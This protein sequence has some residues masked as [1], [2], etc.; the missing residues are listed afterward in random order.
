ME[1]KSIMQ[2]KL[3]MKIKNKTKSCSHSHRKT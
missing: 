1:L 2:Q 3:A